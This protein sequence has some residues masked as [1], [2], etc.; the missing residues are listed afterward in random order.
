[1]NLYR[2]LCFPQQTISSKKVF[3][4][5]PNVHSI[6]WN[7]TFCNQTVPDQVMTCW[8]CAIQAAYNQ[9]LKLCTTSSSSFKLEF[10]IG[11]LYPTIELYDCCKVQEDQKAKKNRYRKK[12]ENHGLRPPKEEVAAI[13]S[14][15]RTFRLRVECSTTVPPSPGSELV[16]GN[17]HRL[18]IALKSSW[19]S[20]HLIHSK[21]FF[22]NEM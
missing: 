15:N 14:E 7:L 12:K 17:N 1:M 16:T 21:M 3:Y 6:C 2:L 8:K 22:K 19:C 5:S 10:G 9:R 11:Q 20:H 18:L 13:G 4:V